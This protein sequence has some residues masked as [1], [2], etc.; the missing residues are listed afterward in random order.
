MA[1][2]G[3]ERAAGFSCNE[4]ARRTVPML[5]PESSIFATS[6]VTCRFIGG[7]G[8]CEGARRIETTFEVGFNCRPLILKVGVSC[9]EAISKEKVNC[10]AVC[11]PPSGCWTDMVGVAERKAG[12]G[13][14]VVSGM[15]SGVVGCSR[16]GSV[17]MI[18]EA[19]DGVSIE[20]CGACHSAIGGGTAASGSTRTRGA[21]GAGEVISAVT[22]SAESAVVSCGIG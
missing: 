22:A 16:M 1:K 19:N 7:C 6:N 5:P 9:I 11:I 14:I 3:E 18:L 2:E 15:I 17:V 13:V 21:S 12:A 20:D 8:S 4:G 10:T